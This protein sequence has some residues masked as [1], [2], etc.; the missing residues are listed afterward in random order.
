MTCVLQN[1]E[2]PEQRYRVQLEQLAAMGFVNREANLQCMY[3]IYHS[4]FIYNPKLG[5]EQEMQNVLDTLDF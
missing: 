2:P 3:P 4:L 1:Q 5:R